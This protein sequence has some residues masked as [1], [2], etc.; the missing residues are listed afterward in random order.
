MSKEASLAGWSFAGAILGLVLPFVWMLG[1]FW[2]T[3]EEPFDFQ[4]FCFLPVVALLFYILSGLTCVT[5]FVGA[6]IGF[7][8]G[9][10][11]RTMR[12]WQ[13]QVILLAVIHLAAVIWYWIGA[14][15]P[16][17]AASLS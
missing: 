8:C 17:W 7:L 10:L 5:P 12:P 9:W 6:A 11:P 3:A 13:R 4:M 14:P 2:I 16:P 15:L 1:Y